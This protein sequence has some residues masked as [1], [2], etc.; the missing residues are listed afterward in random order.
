MKK[1]IL[2][3]GILLSNYANA[4]MDYGFEIGPRQQSGEVWG[5]NFAANA[6]WG[7]QGGMFVHM[8]IDDRITHF[9][10]GLLYT[11]RPIQ[12]HNIVT[13]ENIDYHLDYLDIPLQFL[14][15][16]KENVGFYFG[17][18]A[19]INLSKSCSGNP[20]CQVY[21]VDTPYFP[22]VFG[23]IFKFT[24]KF[25]VNFYLEGAN[26]EIA[27]GIGDFKSVGLNFMLSLD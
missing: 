13:G 7:F 15:K 11:Q 20:N 3:L 10:T 1:Y 22:M 21:D 2:I 17:M 25:G 18:N 12:S 4:A 24:P 19:G 5:A 6:M 16:P 23:G 26:G 9:R 14:F 8:P 27:Q